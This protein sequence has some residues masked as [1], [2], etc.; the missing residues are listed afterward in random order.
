MDGKGKT[1]FDRKRWTWWSSTWV[2]WLWHLCAKGSWETEGRET[3]QV[4]TGSSLLGK[5]SR[6]GQQGK[7]SWRKKQSPGAQQVSLQRPSP[8]NSSWPP[9]HTC[10]AFLPTPIKAERNTWPCPCVWRRSWDHILSLNS[11]SENPGR[12]YWELLNR[13]CPFQPAC[14]QRSG[15]IRIGPKPSRHGRASAAP[16]G[17][18]YWL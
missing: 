5:M 11:E 8:R 4:S 18:Y 13:P 16:C 6:A 9:T 10:L 7:K 15:W 17:C 1:W 2:W 12:A 14:S 3:S